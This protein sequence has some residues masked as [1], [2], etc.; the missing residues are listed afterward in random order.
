M[1]SKR[2]WHILPAASL[3][4][5]SVYACSFLVADSNCA[6]AVDSADDVGAFGSIT[7]TRHARDAAKAAKQGQ[8]SAAEAAYKSALSLDNKAGDL[9]YGLYNAAAHSNNW[10][11]AT[12]ALEDIFQFEPAA[13]PH[14]LAEYGQCLASAGRLEEA[15]PILKKALVTADADAGFLPGKLQA[16]MIKT[17]KVV[18]PFDRP[19]TAKE[20]EDA[21]NEVKVFKPAAIPYVDPDGL[22]FRKSSKALSYEN[23]YKYCEFIGICTFE[24]YDKSDDITFYHPPVARFRIEK[25]LKGPKLNRAMPVRFEFHDKSDSEPDKDWKFTADKMPTKGS[26]WLLFSEMA[27]PTNGAF[28]TYRGN[29]GRQEATPENLNKMYKVMELHRGQQ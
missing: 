10:Q 27:I 15:V 22:T 23:A 3:A 26:K 17:D 24:S 18:H 25:I 14:L 21:A 6:Y 19:H 4:C 1:N 16:L 11:Q 9:N 12:T 28:E 8:W 29:Y 20:L 7:L 2:G 5:L 13:K